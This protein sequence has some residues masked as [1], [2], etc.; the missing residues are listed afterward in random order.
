MKI[1][2]TSDIHGNEEQYKKLIEFAIESSA[3]A[4][5]IG[6]DLAPKDDPTDY[7]GSQEKVL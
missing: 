6:G 4:V 2:Y 7:M 3:S 5:I 1:I